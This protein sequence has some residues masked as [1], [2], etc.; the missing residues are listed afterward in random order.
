MTQSARV[1]E[2]SMSRRVTM[3]HEVAL[4]DDRHA[5]HTLVEHQAG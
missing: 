3:P 1:M 4:V 5:A 2:R